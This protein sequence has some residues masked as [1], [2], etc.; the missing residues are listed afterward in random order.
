MRNLKKGVPAICQGRVG[1]VKVIAR[2]TNEN[3][4]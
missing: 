2:N 4:K 3:Q 1:E